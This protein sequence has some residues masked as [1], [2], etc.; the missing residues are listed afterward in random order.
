MWVGGSGCFHCAVV[1]NINDLTT[2]CFVWLTFWALSLILIRLVFS[3]PAFP[4]LIL[5]AGAKIRI[6]QDA[7]LNPGHTAL[8]KL[9]LLP[10]STLR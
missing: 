5:A 7:G 2:L 1:V 9:G 4:C 6:V 8:S 3:V 10:E